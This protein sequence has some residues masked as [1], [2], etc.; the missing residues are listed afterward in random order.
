MF[1]NTPESS[2]FLLF[3]PV[4][5]TTIPFSPLLSSSSV[6]FL[7]HLQLPVEHPSPLFF[8]TTTHSHLILFVSIATITIRWWGYSRSPVVIAYSRQLTTYY[9][10]SPSSSSSSLYSPQH[11]PPI[12]N[13]L[14][15]PPPPSQTPQP[16]P[17]ATSNSKDPGA[18]PV[19]L[20]SSPQQPSNATR[21]QQPPDG[22]SPPTSTSPS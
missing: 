3:L 5:V 14:A 12:H 16:Q 6:L 21:P 17:N 1:M 15:H 18:Q 11:H 19:N 8:L 4:C 10:S 9:H 2:Y 22:Q 13:N 7:F 20:V